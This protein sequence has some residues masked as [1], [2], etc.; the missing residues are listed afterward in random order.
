[1]QC[2]QVQE[3]LSASID[4]MLLPSELR[5]LEEH[6]KECPDCRRDF[7]VLKLASGLVQN[8][9][10]VELPKE[11]GRN[12]RKRLLN[13]E[14]IIRLPRNKD[15]NKTRFW[16]WSGLLGAASV[17]LIWGIVF[18]GWDL[19]S[20]NR[21]ESSNIKVIEDGSKKTEIIGSVT[22]PGIISPP[23]ADLK[24]NEPITATSQPPSGSRT[25]NYLNDSKDQNRGQIIIPDAVS[26][27]S[28]GESG[29][30]LMTSMSIA[31]SQQVVLEVQATDVK[32]AGENIS[33]ILNKRNIVTAAAE[34]NAGY[35]VRLP[36]SELADVL[37]Q[38]SELGVFVGHEV[39]GYDGS[40]GSGSTDNKLSAKNIGKP[41]DVKDNL[42]VIKD[43]R[44]RVAKNKALAP[45]DS[46]PQGE[47]IL[48]EIFIK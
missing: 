28:E 12:L 30:A 23:M 6:L 7:E 26:E 8:L 15:S 41:K 29:Q 27:L 42:S 40:S 44:E 45:K 4:G 25:A 35:S 10:P 11:F 1:M 20:N 5:Q 36:E 31:S 14:I 48:L 19:Y 22:K 3:L 16:V 33:A 46:L 17:L 21:T 18:S 47:D 38:I 37:S 13:E 24:N 43:I 34:N 32:E 39:S 2:H 9:P